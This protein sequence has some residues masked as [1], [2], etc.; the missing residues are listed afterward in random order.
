MHRSSLRAAVLALACAVAVVVGTASAAVA[1]QNRQSGLV[2]V[3]LQDLNLQVPVSVAAPISV[4]A[5]VCD[6]N[7]LAIRQGNITK[8]D[9]Q[10]NSRGL[11]K[12]IAN[13]MLG[14]GGGGSNSQRGLVNVNVQDLNLQVPV[15]V[16][17]PISAAAN[18]C[19]VSVLSLRQLN[20][21]ECN[22]QSSSRAL[23]RALAKALFAQS[24]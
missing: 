10:S 17:L 4:A 11:S 8:C 22:A 21:T 3:N 14:T 6:V 7:V 15:S 9:A 24:A 2:N 13:E 18:V 19:D 20:A 5:N 23:S 16:A 1:Q 12:A